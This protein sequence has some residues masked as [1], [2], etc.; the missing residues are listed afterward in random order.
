MLSV[1]LAV[2]F[3]P[4]AAFADDS[5]D[6]TASTAASD[7]AAAG[8]PAEP[9]FD[10][11]SS[12]LSASPEAAA[13]SDASIEP[14][15]LSAGERAVTERVVQVSS[16]GTSFAALT[17]SGV[18][19]TWGDN[20]LGQCGAG[21]DVDW[22]N[23]PQAVL[24]DVKQLTGGGDGSFAAV[25]N[26]GSLYVWGMNLNGQL[27]TG[28]TASVY[29]P[30]KVMDNVGVADMGAHG[31]A[32]TTDGWLYVSGTQEA[33]GIPSGH[34]FQQLADYD[35]VSAVSCI[36]GI[37]A[38][39]PDGTLWSCG[40]NAHGLLMGD[41]GAHDAF[42][43][44]LP[45]IRVSRVA[46]DGSTVGIVGTD[47][48]A[49]M[50]GLNDRGQ[51][52]NGTSYNANTSDEWVTTPA[53]L[54]L[55][56]VVDLSVGD[57]SVAAVSQGGVLYTWG[58]GDSGQLGTGSQ[59]DQLWPSLAQ[60]NVSSAEMGLGSLAFIKKNGSLWVSGVTQR[61]DMSWIVSTPVQMLTAIYDTV[62]IDGPNTP[63]G[64]GFKLGTSVSFGIPDSVPLIGGGSVDLGLD[65]VP[66]QFERE[67]NTF[68][69]GIGTNDVGELV[70]SGGWTS[71]KKFVETQKQSLV[72]GFS[73]LDLAKTYDTVVTQGFKAAPKLSVWG[74][75]EGTMNS[76][77]VTSVSGKISFGM[78]V[79]GTQEWQ[80]VLV[81]V[82]VVV[83]FSAEVGLNATAK[84]GF[85]FPQSEVYLSGDVELTLPK[86]KLTGGAGIAWVADIGVYGSAKNAVTVHAA[87][88]S[89]NNRVEASLEGELGARA[90][91]L[92]F[93]YEK[94][95]LQGTW[96]YYSGTPSRARAA[97]ALSAASSDA[98][99]QGASEGWFG[100]NRVSSSAWNGG[101]EPA[102]AAMAAN[103]ENVN[104]RSAALSS[105]MLE[106][107]QSSVYSGTDPQLVQ[108][109]SGAKVMVLTQDVPDRSEGN[110]T[111]VA[112]SVYDEASGWSEPVIVDDDKTA[113]FE[114]SVAV[115]GENVWIAWSNASREF[116]PEEVAAADFP[117]T[118]ASSC[119]IVCAKLDA[120]SGQVDL[121]QVTDDEAYDADASVAVVDGAPQV[122][123][124]SNA[125]GTPFE[126]SGQNAVMLARVDADAP[127]AQ[128]VYRSDVPVTAVAAGALGGQVAVA[129]V[130][131]DQDEDA[132]AGSGT[133]MLK[134]GAANCVAVASGV[135][136]P[137]FSTVREAETLL[138]YAQGEEGG[139][140]RAL[141]EA[142]GKP[143]DLIGESASFTADYALT[144]AG[145]AGQL[146]LC[147]IDK[148]D[149]ALDPADAQ[150]APDG[151]DV[152]AY[153]VEDDGVTGPAL[154]TDAEGYAS[155]AVGVA[156][157]DGWTVALLRSDVQ[158][159]SDAGRVLQD[160]D[161]C[162]LEVAPS[163]QI[164]I[165]D[166]VPVDEE[167]IG[168]GFSVTV[169]NTGLASGGGGELELYRE[170]EDGHVGWLDDDLPTLAPGESAV[171]EVPL[172]YG[173]SDALGKTYT[174][175][176]E[177]EQGSGSELS[178]T[179]GATNVSLSRV[180]Y[181]PSET[182]YGQLFVEAYNDGSYRTDMTVR[183][184]ANNA[185]GEVLLERA[186]DA[187][188]EFRRSYSFSLTGDEL[189][190]I[191]ESGAEALYVEVSCDLPEAYLTDNSTTVYIGDD[192]LG[193]L[194]HLRA[195]L[196]TTTYDVNEGFDP[197]RD[198][199]LKAVY[200]DGAEKVLAPGEY[201]TNLGELDLTVP[202]EN[203]VV[204][205]YEEVGIAR[206]VEV[207]ITMAG[208]LSTQTFTLSF[209][210][211]GGSAVPSQ[212]VVAGSAPSRPADPAREGYVFTGWFSDADCTQPF[213]FAAP[214]N[215]DATAYA[216]WEADEQP[217]VGPGTD[218]DPDPD[219][220]SPG[221]GDPD[222]G[223]DPDNP[224]GGDSD[225]ETPGGD[226]GEGGGSDA[227][228][229]GGSEGEGGA[230]GSGVSGESD[231]AEGSGS[232]AGL[233]NV[234]DGL[235]FAAGM[236]ALSAVFAGAVAVAALRRRDVR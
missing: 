46:T 16:S 23:D 163:A 224:D 184:R 136:S 132:E 6:S 130:V 169:K 37:L 108:T 154:L 38:I 1:T 47:G 135:A 167:Y 120:A 212:E 134:Q 199:V 15:A 222:P 70:D 151:A 18:V 181:T 161:L 52:G 170:D 43:Q 168:G 3:V 4:A 216:G 69:I 214:L 81:V 75:A 202:G 97:N 123:W 100:I 57:G 140:L 217:P 218:P 195:E 208:E 207:P 226:T 26:D 233:K 25:K 171:V 49:W 166:A 102:A 79:K 54:G 112:Y 152:V 29:Q 96:T 11:G 232:D 215:S 14:R 8:T 137:V 211:Q 190:E 122:A 119:D 65:F 39:M 185:D 153:L 88:N 180:N 116:S 30:R 51:M 236:A 174:F 186:S 133:L 147:S 86:M 94:P 71:F 229:G 82:P 106:T 27:G 68:R 125:D 20:K 9:S 193:T 192:V 197:A 24:D 53:E 72:T 231:S 101:S 221:G 200:E 89:G 31:L 219:P 19:Y 80:A 73:G 55:M 143:F 115:D 13:P 138:W 2:G 76:S 74:Y 234:G 173:D 145:A 194:D 78:S 114:P 183:L 64:S 91:A 40:S 198:M 35:F 44:V 179:A 61:T 189:K 21:T 182:G 7:V 41:E 105:A 127:D 164:S 141:T 131:D 146:V 213:D 139:S 90:R 223:T 175:V 67:G 22:V 92:F 77:G 95:F 45:S 209:D 128:E 204:V 5:T 159:D 206:S 177:P 172:Y 98:S 162:T 17:E 36:D 148:A 111:A 156:D 126:L 155:D 60:E 144:D 160:A 196:A 10:E 12:A 34:S 50:W 99:G 187:P 93:E 59:S 118:L 58:A 230:S 63:T 235:G 113:D 87:T 121:H 150:D 110:H 117:Q 83:T 203:T 201:T 178:I 149:A 62:V 104:G 85:D 220:D 48:R 109:E 142:D 176:A 56:D 225:P 205:S 84:V 28:D 165:V 227:G 158:V 191:E 124:I 228:D 157:D 42:E 32:I 129:F 210:A 66:V 188:V 103:A 107:L 33:T